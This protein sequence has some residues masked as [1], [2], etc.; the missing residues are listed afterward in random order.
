[1]SLYVDDILYTSSSAEMIIEFK[2]EMT[3]TFDM[4]DLGLVNYFL[5]LEVKQL[6]SGIFI[7]Q[8][9][10]VYDLVAQLGMEKC[11]PVGTPMCINDQHIFEEG[12]EKADSSSY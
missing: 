3:S 4:S 5:G 7:T 9:K 2:R 6:A 1:M 11:N 10:Y 8:K 12:A